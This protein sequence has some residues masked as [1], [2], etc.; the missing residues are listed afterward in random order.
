MPISFYS[1]PPKHLKADMVL[2]PGNRTT[3]FALKQGT[4]PAC[5]VDQVV[6]ILELNPAKTIIKI[7]RKEDFLIHAFKESSLSDRVTFL[8]LQGP[9]ASPISC[10]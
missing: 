6:Y 2:N 7:D 9:T 4:T 10:S 1:F 8:E 5:A 3:F